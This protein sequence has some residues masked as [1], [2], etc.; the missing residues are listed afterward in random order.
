MR[1]LELKAHFADL[2]RAEEIA[3]KLNATFEGELRQTDTYFHV[4]QGRLKLREIQHIQPDESADVFR[5]ELIAYQRPEDTAT[6][7][8]DYV[9]SVITA[10][11]TLRAV[12]ARALDVRQVVTKTRRL[13]LYQGSRI[14]LDCVVGLGNF[15]EFEVLADDGDEGHARN[16]MSELMRAFSLQDDDA[17]TASYGEMG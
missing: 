12:L 14:H 6:R 10:P 15:I 11:D 7:W 4:P 3:R 1:N 17:I 16:V 8:S 9:T 13:Y 2:I 5:A